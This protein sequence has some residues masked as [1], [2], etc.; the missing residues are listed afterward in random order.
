MIIPVLAST[1]RRTARIA[2]ERPRAGLWAQL[3]LACALFAVAAAGVAAFSVERWIAARPPTTA[4]MVVYLADGMPE[5]RAREL[6]EQLRHTG[7]AL[8]VE[9]VP[10]AESAKRLVAALGADAHLLDGIDLAQLPASVEVRLAPGVRD[11]IGLSP[12]VRALRGSPGVADVV[13]EDP[14]DERIVGALDAVRAIAWT[15][16]A[17]FAGLALI[18][19]LATIRVRMD[20]T[21]AE[22]AVAK[23]LGASPGF[24]IWPTLLAGALHGALAGT[25]AS[26]ALALVL[27]VYAGDITAAL[28]PAL[29]HVELAAPG[30][31]L[32]VLVGLG[33]TIGAIGG[34]LAG[35]TREEA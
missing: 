14:T 10:P 9:L 6:A 7:G 33:A 19:V 18:V 26:G 29:G 32:L 31:G 25:L 8:A 11:V 5:A 1:L 15:G 24:W 2:V 21:H 28:A 23:L 20:R 30:I 3:A 12:T 4:A 17:L 22:L 13:L 16:A 35:A 34:V 27:A